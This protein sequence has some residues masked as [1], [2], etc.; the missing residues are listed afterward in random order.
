M[1]QTTDNDADNGRQCRQWTSMHMMDNNA[2]GNN[3]TQ[4]TG[5]K[6]DNNVALQRRQQGDMTIQR[7]ADNGQ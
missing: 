1:M 7:D 5:N 2:H 6:A 4:T 3:A